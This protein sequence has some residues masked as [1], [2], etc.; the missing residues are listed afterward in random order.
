VETIGISLQ[1]GATKEALELALE[2]LTRANL[3]YLRDH[4][5]VP[6]LYKSGVRYQREARGRETWRTI[7]EVLRAGHGDCEDLSAFLA[8]QLRQ[9]GIPARCIATQSGNLWHIT[10]IAS[11]K[12]SE[13]H[14]DPSRVLGM[15]R[16]KKRT[17]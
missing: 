2:Y 13:I 10:V 8:A 1:V 7:P 9:R 5:R 16:R 17:K 14:Y 11:V 4:P 12:G 15:G 6:A 3:L